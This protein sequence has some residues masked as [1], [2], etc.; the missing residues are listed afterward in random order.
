M[1]PLILLSLLM[2]WL[3][4]H[5]QAASTMRCGTKLVSLGATMFEVKKKCGEPAS[6]T[7]VGTQQRGDFFTDRQV[8]L[9]EEGI[10]SPAGGMYQ[11]LRFEGDRLKSIESTRNL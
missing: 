7:T 11:I 6:Q 2:L 10:Y 8:L 3:T 4:P 1:R 5:A 9:I